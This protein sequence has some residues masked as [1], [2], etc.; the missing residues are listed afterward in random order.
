MSSIKFLAIKSTDEITSSHRRYSVRKGVLRNFPKFTGKHL[1]FIS[2]ETLTQV[3][4]CE[5]YKI[6][7]NTLFTEH[8]RTTSPVVI[9]ELTIS[10]LSFMVIN[11]LLEI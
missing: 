1:C 7:S 10:S 9:E 3:F 5:F 2:K 8:L 6:S 11:G 4:S